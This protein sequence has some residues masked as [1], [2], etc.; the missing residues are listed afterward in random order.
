MCAVT[1]NGFSKMVH[2]LECETYLALDRG[3]TDSGVIC[4]ILQL[5]SQLKQTLIELL[6]LTLRPTLSYCIFAAAGISLQA[7]I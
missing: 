6:S 4:Q 2:F 3:N 7:T 5:H 1:C